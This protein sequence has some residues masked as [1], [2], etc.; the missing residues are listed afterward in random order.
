MG[1]ITDLIY[2]IIYCI[3]VQDLDFSWADGAKE[4]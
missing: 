4:G 3:L 2:G 1:R